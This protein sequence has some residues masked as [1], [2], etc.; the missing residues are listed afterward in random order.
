MR[1]QAFAMGLALALAA[2]GGA[3]ADD[4]RF[5]ISNG[6][7]TVASFELYLKPTPNGPTVPGY[8]FSLASVPAMVGGAQTTLG[9]L[10]F[11]SAVLGGGFLAQD[12]SGKDVFNFSGQQLYSES[13]DASNNAL[14]KL[15]DNA[16]VFTPGSY[17]LVVAG[18]FPRKTE[19]VTLTELFTDPPPD[20]PTVSIPEPSTW[21]MLLLGFVGLA[22]AGYRKATARTVN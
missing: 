13:N 4:V 11:Y 18:A 19:T 1:I 5:T 21:A 12:V 3:R 9:N 15:L 17:Q 10:T 2:A 22:F 6:G 20:P 7:K 8:F 14:S 16:P